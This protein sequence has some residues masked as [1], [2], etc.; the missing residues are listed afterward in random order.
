MMGGQIML[1]NT[2]DIQI[3]KSAGANI[4]VNSTCVSETVTVISSTTMISNH[5]A[6]VY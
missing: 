4:N 2:P 3:R 6:N 1:C 5:A